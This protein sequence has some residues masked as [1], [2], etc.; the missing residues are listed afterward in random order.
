MES[1]RKRLRHNLTV[2]LIPLVGY[3]VVRFLALT[4]RIEER[5]SETIA[6]FDKEKKPF[7]SAFW[8]GHL[9]MMMISPYRKHSKTM[10]S[11]HRDGE[12]I[13]RLAGLFGVG[14]IRGSTTEGGVQALKGAI[15]AIREGYK[16]NVTP[17]GPRGPRHTV[18]PGVIELA[19]ATGVPII[20]V[21]FS[22]TRKKVF[23]SWD[24]FILPYPFS[25][26]VFFYGPPFYVERRVSREGREARR[27]ELEQLM[28][29]M[30][31][32]VER[33]CETGEWVD[34]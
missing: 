1:Y 33:Y 15:R 17:D 7:V 21:V 29:R 14:S 32:Q 8:H 16:V 3:G 26:G 4:M 18:Q 34:E 13:S 12:M 20:P 9:L 24:R 5:G 6:A 23:S 2:H 25:R 28:R 19:R 10:I 22:C 11:R 31:R 30:T 27:R